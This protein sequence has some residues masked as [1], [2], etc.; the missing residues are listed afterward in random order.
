LGIFNTAG[1]QIS[2]FAMTALSV[3]RIYHLGSIVRGGIDNVYAK[4]KI[5]GV[6]TVIFTVSFVLAG[7]PMIK[8]LEDFFVNGLF[9]EQ[10]PL[11]TAS[12]SKNTHR[13]IFLEH[14]GR[15]YLKNRFSW[16]LIRKMVRGMFTD[17]YGGKNI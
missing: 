6:I 1:S 12:V 15:T 10:N 13:D 7:L 3:F 5:T 11:F 8:G 17:D 9:Y 14:Y 16:E 2:L 4:L